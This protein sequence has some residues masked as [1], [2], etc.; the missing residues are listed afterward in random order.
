MKI[1]NLALTFFSLNWIIAICFIFRG[2]PDWHSYHMAYN[3]KWYTEALLGNIIDNVMPP[4]YVWI[5]N[6]HIL[7]PTLELRLVSIISFA[8]LAYIIYKQYGYKSS[9]YVSSIPYI[10][11]WATRAHTDMLMSLL[12]IG[13]FILTINAN[14]NFTGGLLI[15]LSMFVKPISAWLAIL[16]FNAKYWIGMLIGTIPF[17]IWLYYHPESI[18]FH[19]GT[20]IPFE[21]Y[22]RLIIF[23]AIALIPTIAI[24]MFSKQ[25]IKYYLAIGGFLVFIFYKAQVGHEYY[26]LPVLLLVGLLV[27]IN[28]KKYW[29][30]II[31]NSIISIGLTI[32][33]N[34][35]LL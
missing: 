16:K 29:L 22:K 7:P 14:K 33:L 13:G 21:N 1:K 34:T 30:M 5:S 17:A 11:L 9:I 24:M 20:S 35:T 27:N 25:Y 6:W 28:H 19:E 18:A 10:A 2:I 8:M 32:T 26:L 23:G 15:G 4:G 31:L 12:A 3:E